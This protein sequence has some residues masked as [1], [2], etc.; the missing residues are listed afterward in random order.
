MKQAF[1]R[2][3]E[4]HYVE[5]FARTR[6]PP[7]PTSDDAILPFRLARSDMRGRVVRLESSLG[8]ILQQHRYPGAVSALVSEAVLLTVLIGQTINF[9][10]KFSIQV[11]G[12]GAVRLIATDY[13]APSKEGEVAHLRA[14]AGYDAGD[15]ASARAAPFALL[16]K[17]VFGVTI[18][19]GKHTKPYQGITPLAGGSLAAC[20]ET[21]FAQS[22]Q[23]ATRFKLIGAEAQEPGAQA[24]WRGAGIMLQQMPTQGGYIPDA[25]SGQDGMMTADDAA[26]MG[27]REED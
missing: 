22:E 8:T 6:R 20:A 7:M 15:V 3:G 23:L 5:A 1:A 12:E 19:Q 14:Y 16:G 4:T 9:G 10:W 18:D 27:G 2:R 17:G 26:A 13:F 24:T 25:P 11:R 21:Y